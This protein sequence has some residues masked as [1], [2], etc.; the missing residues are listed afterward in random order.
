MLIFD[1]LIYTFNSSFHTKISRMYFIVQKKNTKKKKSQCGS[2]QGLPHI[3]QTIRGAT[4]QVYV[5]EMKKEAQ[6]MCM[7][8]GGGKDTGM[9]T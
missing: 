8:E 7:E 4:W 3:E 9:D 5:E 6:E 2:T 1:Y